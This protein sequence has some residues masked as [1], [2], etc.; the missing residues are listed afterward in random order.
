MLA[1]PCNHRDSVELGIP[2]SRPSAV[3]VTAPGPTIRRTIRAR[4]ASEYAINLLPLSPR[5]L[6]VDAATTLTQG[7]NLIGQPESV[8]EQIPF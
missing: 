6:Q 3:T 8:E 4:T 7:D 5:S 1:A 2:L